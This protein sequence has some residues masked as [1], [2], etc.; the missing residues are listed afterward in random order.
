[1]TTT[2]SFSFTRFSTL[3]RK[4][5]LE[6]WKKLLMYMIIT[7]STLI[8]LSIITAISRFN[9]YELYLQNPTWIQSPA[10]TTLN[11]LM[12]LFVFCFFIF[13]F[14]SASM[15]MTSMKN[16]TGCISTLMTPASQLEKYLVRVTIYVIGFVVFY[17][18]CCILADLAR[19]A[20]TVSL[21]PEYSGMTRLISFRDISSCN[22]DDSITVMAYIFV[23]IQSF[24]VL[25]SSIWAKN[26]FVKT[27]IALVILNLLFTTVGALSLK[28]ILEG[29]RKIYFDPEYEY[30][31]YTY[32][33]KYIKYAIPAIILMINYTLAYYRFKEAEIINRI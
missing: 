8:I 15:T 21:H 11:S 13:G 14:I 16:K 30:Q 2:D 26:S 19:Y 24:F 4:Y 29:R 5:I 22:D 10:D 23:T 1:M 17:I 20:L 6:N 7:A 3:M 25:G 33:I 12:S 32:A 27:F 31:Q 9:V 28:L 18:L